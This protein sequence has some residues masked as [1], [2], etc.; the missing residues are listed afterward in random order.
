MSV[1]N[2]KKIYIERSTEK[3]KQ[4]YLKV[5][6]DSL[7]SAMYNLGSSAFMLWIYFTDN[8][9]GY[10]LDLYPVDFC[11]ITGLSDS[12]YRRAFKELEEKGYLIQ[13]SKQK[14][15]YLFKE[16]SAKAAYP[17]I[18]NSIDTDSFNEIKSLFFEE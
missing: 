10:P 2:Q 15:L 1:P 4:N 5:S 8:S 12:T 14:N 13:S 11:S 9:N 17:D 6:N 7:K 16:I 18:V 3:V